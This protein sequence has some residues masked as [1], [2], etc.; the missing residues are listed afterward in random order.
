MDI[1]PT[2]CDQLPTSILNDIDGRTVNFP[3]RIQELPGDN[4]VFLSGPLGDR[5]VSQVT[6]FVYE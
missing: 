5:G 6:P 2:V 1:L 3:R 4:G